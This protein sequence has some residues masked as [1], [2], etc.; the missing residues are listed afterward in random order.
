MIELHEKAVADFNVVIRKNPKNAH[1][2]FRRAF[3]LKSL[4]V[5]SYY[6]VAL[7][8]PTNIVCAEIRRVCGRL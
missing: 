7:A 2:F 4:K 5:R 6:Y 3:S 8:N 1:A